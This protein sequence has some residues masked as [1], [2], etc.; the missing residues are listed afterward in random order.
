MTTTTTAIR[1]ARRDGIT[2]SPEADFAQT[3][4]LG[5]MGVEGLSPDALAAN[6][7]WQKGSKVLV[8]DIAARNA[9]SAQGLRSVHIDEVVVHA[10]AA[11][12]S[13]RLITEGRPRLFCHMIKFTSASARQV[14]SVVSFEH[15]TRT[16]S[17]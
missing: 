16:P 3:V 4:A 5:L 14:A 10:T 11:A 2:R 17:S 8:G 7:T 9:I 1:T 13:G 6:V 12:V 15:Q